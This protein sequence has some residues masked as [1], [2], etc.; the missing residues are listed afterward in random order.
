MDAARGVYSVLG[1]DGCLL[2]VRWIGKKGMVTAR[3]GV[4]G[5]RVEGGFEVVEEE[6]RG[7]EEGGA[8]CFGCGREHGAETSAE[9]TLD[10]VETA[11]RVE[12]CAWSCAWSLPIYSSGGR[13]R[14]YRPPRLHGSVG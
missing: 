8:A 14:E 7:S 12:S 9:L 11:W 6:Q 3:E 2:R 4:R 13:G 1:V 10:G 5:E